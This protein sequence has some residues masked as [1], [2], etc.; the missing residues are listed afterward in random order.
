M[1]GIVGYL[2]ERQAEQILY[3][4]L[5][6]LEY[7]GYDSA[8][9]CVISPKKELTCI[10]AVGNLDA[11]GRELENFDLHGSIGIGHTRW[12]THGAPTRINAHPHLDCKNDV[13][14]VHNGIIENFVQLRAELIA[15]GH[16]FR[17]QT[18]SETIAHLIEENYTG[19]LA[20][21]LCTA[22]K[23]VEGAFAIVAIHRD[24][25]GVLVAARRDSPLALGVGDGEYF[26]ASAVP[27]FLSQTRS[28]LFLE[29][30]ELLEVDRG[31]YNLTDLDGSLITRQLAEID[32]DLDAAEKG[33]YED[34]MLK[35]IFEQPQ[36]VADTLRDKFNPGNRVSF[37]QLS[38]TSEQ[39]RNL[40][41]IAVVACGT[42]FHAGLL[43]K[44]LFERW[45]SIPVEI[46]IASEFRYRNLVVNHEDLVVAISQSGET[47][48]TL[49]GVREAEKRGARV[50]AVTNTIGSQMTREAEGVIY[51]HAGPE[52]GV[53]ATKTFAAQVTAMYLLALYLGRLRG[54]ISDERYSSIVAD[55]RA[56]P[57]KIEEVLASES[58]VHECARKYHQCDDFL[59]LGRS[60]GYPVAMEGALKLKEISYIHAEGYPAGEMKHGP[61]ALLDGGVPV[62]VIAT[63]DSVYE[64]MISNIEEVKARGA[65]VLAVATRGDEEIGDIVDD[66]IWVPETR[67]MLYPLLTVVPLQMLAYHVAKL[68][69]CNVDQPRNLAKTVTVE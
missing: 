50:I 2:G 24:Q 8:G 3:D 6:R 36:A 34:F 69:G 56:I 60:V 55:L 47:M 51:T 15:S 9:M 20:Q 27:A 30:N 61:I 33:G 65:P 13:A 32:W 42:A 38:L 14:V 68:R 31:G 21:A 28:V 18:D 26:V 49:A 4:G 1:C 39:A 48:D 54:A 57:S 19:D 23:R 43:A 29:D 7:R 16:E 12:A 64:K 66:V 52:I 40:R 58:S 53:A 17:S 46:E 59:F 67:E 10:R 44:Y 35:E 62:V 45:V 22:L 11:L 41:R 25:P 63:R 37:D 5:R